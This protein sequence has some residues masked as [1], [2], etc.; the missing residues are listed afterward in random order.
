MLDAATKALK[1]ANSLFPANTFLDKE[2]FENI[3]KNN[4]WL[5]FTLDKKTST[6]ISKYHN[7]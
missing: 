4:V 2:L 5:K 3:I 1:L 7:S 6:K